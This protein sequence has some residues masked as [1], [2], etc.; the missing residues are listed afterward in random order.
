M[1]TAILPLDGV[2]QQFEIQPDI[3]YSK[4]LFEEICRLN[5][6]ARVELTRDG[7]IIIMAPTAIESDYQNG[8]AFTQLKIWTRKTKR[9]KAFGPTAGFYLPDGSNRSPDAAWVSDERVNALSPA[10]KRK[11]APLLPEFVVEVKS[12]SD[13]LKKLQEKCSQYL[14]NGV[15]ET[16]LIHPDKRTVFVYKPGQE[17][18]ELV[19]VSSVAASAGPVGFVLELE[20][21]WAGLS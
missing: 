2:E 20:E 13:R 16:W 21:I 14:E 17:V 11:P 7:R 19:G 3:G 5:S 18:Q 9:G 1:M 6:E 12:P 8:E 15:S 10:Q 4:E